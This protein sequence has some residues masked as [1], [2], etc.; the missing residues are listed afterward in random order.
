MVNEK[1]WPQTYVEWNRTERG[2]DRWDSFMLPELVSRCSRN[3]LMLLVKRAHEVF[4][5]FYNVEMVEKQSDERIWDFDDPDGENGHGWGVTLAHKRKH[6]A[7]ELVGCM[8]NTGCRHVKPRR[9]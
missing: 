4:N 8:A 2:L 3:E 9:K 1:P 7:N 5:D 6:L